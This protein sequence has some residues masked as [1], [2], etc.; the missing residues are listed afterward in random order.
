MRVSLSMCDTPKASL[1]LASAKWCVLREPEG[2]FDF[3]YGLPATTRVPHPQ[4]TQKLSNSEIVH[5]KRTRLFPFCVVFQ[6]HRRVISLID[7]MFGSYHSSPP[8]PHARIR[9]PRFSLL[10]PRDHYDEATSCDHR[11]RHND[12]ARSCQRTQVISHSLTATPWYLL[13]R[14]G[15]QTRCEPPAHQASQRQPKTS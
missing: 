4:L 2:W 11:E 12:T 6:A 13:S 8:V 3:Q 14:C 5:G 15:I 9:A 7:M 10:P 1:Y